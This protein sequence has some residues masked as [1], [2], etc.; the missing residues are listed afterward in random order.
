MSLLSSGIWMY[1][2]IWLA[3]SKDDLFWSKSISPEAD[4]LINFVN[5]INFLL[6]LSMGPGKL[7]ENRYHHKI[8]FY[9]T[10]LQTLKDKDF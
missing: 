6:F 3:I 7:I 10:L 8:F 4:N 5:S 2:F 1:L 9:D